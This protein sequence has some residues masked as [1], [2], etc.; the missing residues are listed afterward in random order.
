MRFTISNSTL[1]NA[2]RLAKGF[3]AQREQRPVLKTLHIK[4]NADDQS[5]ILEATDSA[6]AMRWL[7]PTTVS[8]SGE[9]IFEITNY[10]LSLLVAKKKLPVDVQITFYEEGD[11]LK[12]NIDDNIIVLKR[13]NEASK[14]P[15]MSGVF[16]VKPLDS[17]PMLD[18]D[19]LIASLKALASAGADSV[20]LN[21]QEGEMSK[22]KIIGKNRI[23]S[24]NDIEAVLMPLRKY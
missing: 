5:I 22:I 3:V 13:K 6:R 20:I 24:I 2:L 17:Q 12:A 21:I 15:N 1:I 10:L 14:Y 4:A 23:P 18:I 16:D 8:E 9:C 11:C 19:C 7:I